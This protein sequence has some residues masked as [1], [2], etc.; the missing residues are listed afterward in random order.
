VTVTATA[1][2][3]RS[4]DSSVTLTLD[5][6]AQLNALDVDA[7]DALCCAILT[8]ASDERTRAIVLT[9]AGRAFC[10]GAD[11]RRLPSDVGV[12][13]DAAN[14][15]VRAMTRADVPVITAVNGPA[16]GFGVALVAASD[17]VL[18]AES[19]YLTLP[20]TSL[21]MMPDGGLTHTL[22]AI[23]GS[24]MAGDLALTGRRLSAVEAQRVGLVSRVVSDGDL[25]ATVDATTQV[26]ARRSRQALT[27]TKRALVGTGSGALDAALELER[28]GQIELLASQASP[29][30]PG[31]LATDRP[32]EN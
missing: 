1:I 4:V 26:L 6:D 23:V 25:A 19:A 9:G 31:Y 10:S 27:L 2:R 21:G 15:V 16:V 20:F 28:S 32:Q 13:M 8:A 30:G 24:A 17:I 29:V 18:A 7:L 22:P 11:L 14:A 3:I 12:I 5:G